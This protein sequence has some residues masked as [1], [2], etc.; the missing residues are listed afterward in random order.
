MAAYRET[1]GHFVG[2]FY[3]AYTGKAFWFEGRT[4][5]EVQRILDWHK[6]PDAKIV[7]MDRLDQCTDDELDDMHQLATALPY[8]TH[9]T[10]VT[11]VSVILLEK[12]LKR[13]A[14]DPSRP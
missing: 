2:Y 9:T 10:F 12:E 1:H 14:V 7:D 4:R 8:A 11:T 13:R 3:G 5:N 6:L